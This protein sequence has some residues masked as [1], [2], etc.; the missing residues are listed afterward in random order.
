[1]ISCSIFFCSIK[2][3]LHVIATAP[4]I[5]FLGVL[6]GFNDVV[7]LF[8]GILVC[9]STRTVHKLVNVEAFGVY[10]TVLLVF[11]L[12]AF[13]VFVFVLVLVLF[14][15][16]FLVFMIEFFSVAAVVFAE[17][18]LSAECAVETRTMATI[19]AVAET[20]FSICVALPF[21]VVVAGGVVFVRFSYVVDAVDD[22][23]DFTCRLVGVLVA[24][25]RIHAP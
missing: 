22:V 12:V 9:G 18:V 15:V 21:A 16:A 14:I 24:L 3:A 2:L 17:S 13:L 23:V 7:F 6:F 20:V 8:G 11:V 25:V 10:F 19:A 5:V 1:L 4:H